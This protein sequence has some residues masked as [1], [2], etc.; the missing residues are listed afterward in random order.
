[1]GENKR[2]L[3]F[4]FTALQGKQFKPILFGKKYLLYNRLKLSHLYKFCKTIA[5]LIIYEI[6]R[7]NLN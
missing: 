2:I 5:L 3:H 1:M 4:S 6:K 7:E